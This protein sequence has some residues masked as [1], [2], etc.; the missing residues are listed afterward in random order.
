[1][2]NALIDYLLEHVAIFLA[3]EHLVDVDSGPSVDDRLHDLLSLFFSHNS[4]TEAT[5]I[6]ECLNYI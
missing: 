2:L 6:D 4:E 3:K 1:M 5:V